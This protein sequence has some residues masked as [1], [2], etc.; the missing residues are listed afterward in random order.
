[1]NNQFIELVLK[2]EEK[3]LTKMHGYKKFTALSNKKMGHQIVC[4]TLNFTGASPQ[5]VFV[6]MQLLFEQAKQMENLLDKQ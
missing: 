3:Y 6:K 4:I 5:A 2:D 1:M